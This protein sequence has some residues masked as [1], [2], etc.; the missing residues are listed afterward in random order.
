MAQDYKILI[1]GELSNLNK[2][3]DSIKNL[4]KDTKVKVDLE[5]GGVLEKT[6]KIKKDLYTVVT[7]TQRWN[8]EGQQIAKTQTTVQNNIRRMADEEKKAKKDL[9]EQNKRLARTEKE[10]LKATEDANKNNLLSIKN[11]SESMKT[12]IVR[13]AEWAVSM[14]LLYGSFAKLKDAV[15]IVKQLDNQMTN[16]RMVTGA[17]DAQ[18]K[19]MLRNFQDIAKETSS[20]TSEVAKGAEEF[21]RQGRSAEEAN[22]LIKTSAVF[23][24]VAFLDSAQSAELLTSAIN[25][26]QVSASDAMSVVDK[27]SAIDM[28]A[29]TSSE[30]LAQ[31]MARTANSAR[32]AGVDMD[33]L[34][35][36]IGTVSSVTRGSAESIGNSFKSI[37]ARLQSVRAGALFDEAGEDISKVDKVLQ[38]YD[39]HLRDMSTGTF[40]EASD[41]I[42]ELGKKWSNLENT[43]QSE[44][45]TAVAG[46]LQRERFITLME[47]YSQAV[48]LTE[49]SLN[50]SGSALEK[51][52]I[53]QESTEA[54]LTELRN[55]FEI[56]AT[57][58]IDG[59]LIK[60]II[61]AGK[62]LL[63]FANS[64]IGQLILRLTV[65]AT[66][67][68][69]VSKAF[70]V[71]S[72]IMLTNSSNI[73]I[74]SIQMLATKM[75]NLTQVTSMLTTAMMANPL[76][77]GAM[78]S[79]GIVSF[80]YAI[81]D[82]TDVIGKQVDVVKGLTN[83][84]SNLQSEYDAL[85]GKT[86][87]TPLEQS[88]LVL[89][90]QEIMAKKEAIK[91]ESEYQYQL[92][93]RPK[94][95]LASDASQG[96]G[97]SD[98]IDRY[99]KL[100][101]A[102]TNT[103]KAE[104]DRQQ[105][106]SQLNQKMS[107]QARQLLD[108][109]DKGVQL[110]A[111]DEKLLKTVENI[112][113]AQ[114][115]QIETSAQVSN[116][117]TNA[118]TALNDYTKQLEYL[119]GVEKMVRTN[120]SL[121][122]QQKDELLAKYPELRDK[123]IRTAEGW[124]IEA[125]SLEIVR[126][127]ALQTA[128]DKIRAEKADLENRKASLMAKLKLDKAEIQSAQQVANAMLARARANPNF[129]GS[130]QGFGSPEQGE[131]INLFGQIGEIDKILGS[132]A[133]VSAGGGGISGGKAPSAKKSAD[134][135]TDAIKEAFEKQYKAL[136]H[137]LTMNKISETEYLNKLEI[138]Y[139]KYFSN[140]KKYLD[141][142]NQ[143][144]EEVYTKRKEIEEKR[145]KDK[146]EKEK[147]VIEKRKEAL[148]SLTDLV[149][150]LI[151]FEK[152]QEKD[153]YTDL[154]NQEKERHNEVVEN[155][156]TEVD[157]KKEALEDELDA[158]RKIIE[159]QLE[160]IRL[161]E[162]ERDHQSEL[163]DKQKE[164]AK[165]EAELRE[166]SFDDS[167]EGRAKRLSLEEQIA[168]QKKEIDEFQHDREVELTE[169]ALN[170]ELE[171]YEQSIKEQ[172]DQYDDYLKEEES[173]YKDSLDNR[174]KE[175]EGYVKDIDNY[176]K[177]EGLLRSEANRRI[178]TEG[179]SLYQKLT[180]YNAEYG[181]LSQEA[182]STMWNTA[183]EAMTAYEQKQL[184]VLDTLKILSRE[185]NRVTTALG[186]EAVDVDGGGKKSSQQLN[187]QKY[188]HDLMIKAQS[189]NNTGLISWI[190]GERK[191]WGLD[192]TSGKVIEKFHT[193]IQEGF[194]GGKTG[195]KSNEQLALLMK[196]EGVFTEKQM[197]NFM[198]VTLPT[199]LGM[200]GTSQNSNGI[201]INMPMT[202]EGNVDE[203]V[204]PDLK[205]FV[206]KTVDTAIGQLNNAMKQRGQI[207]NAKTM[208][209]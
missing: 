100:A 95:G 24:K 159:A 22:E 143:Y 190:K 51:F 163:S 13:S 207:R 169:D 48:D 170:K 158:Y 113:K 199:M 68:G 121:S 47:N 38:Q 15:E 14:G 1:E 105:Q 46:T 120:T 203:A 157:A 167:A 36:Y 202:F 18:A 50:S 117:Y 29:A 35:G 154:I 107:E 124:T 195:T 126:K 139:K 109:K 184:S 23:S 81:R 112:A 28:A 161:R 17:T 27:M 122:L 99:N 72:K 182:L 55:E 11:I 129:R 2:I 160:S 177:K 180:D 65:L 77:M 116:H 79:A 168:N 150:D 59:K 71:L 136:Q 192:P 40:R 5:T 133:N 45:A 96:S 135:K 166:V 152:Q 82:A 123:I 9:E 178:E 37:F 127:Q 110:T 176:L 69:L 10:R 4:G 84:L 183:G 16:I 145:L 74:F 62:L 20:L 6:D 63:Q 146:L 12:A 196:G 134:S 209:I 33:T 25:G 171:K 175:Y 141:E 26:Y 187:Q 155:L 58:T 52:N 186:G 94:M 162:S 21:L 104:Y 153:Y 41:V 88:R 86:D 60:S 205:N 132:V 49:V 102:V 78:A 138:L 91:Q 39:V 103:A 147:E 140:K 83:E 119:D 111:Q 144:E 174:I 75:M 156:K 131:L 64:D 201:N 206:K 3:S 197:E 67:V 194:V 61:D 42:D 32:V 149:V 208:A 101:S 114:I 137:Q 90:Q 204:L 185:M 56:F 57:N 106:L 179:Q 125:S 148:N 92:M 151:K 128:N 193:G 19:Q 54:K 115:K 118:K 108:L 43:Q 181:S 31:A 97:L 98:T 85:L 73:I 172:L 130:S 198:K 173:R 142:Y 34:L 66:T 189:E 53:Y 164:L 165:L 80:V 8:K 7:T 30:E 191:K 89:L 87:L 76:F 93:N 188:L 70:S 44:I 200:A